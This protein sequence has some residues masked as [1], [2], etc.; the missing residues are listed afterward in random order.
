MMILLFI[1]VVAIGYYVVKN[2]ARQENDHQKPLS[3]HADLA[4]LKTEVEDLRSQVRALK[5]E[6][7]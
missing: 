4:D 7:D 6:K 3:S 1:A 2:N 5:R